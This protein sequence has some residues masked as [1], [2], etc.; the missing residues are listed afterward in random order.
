VLTALFQVVANNKMLLTLYTHDHVQLKGEHLEAV[1]STIPQIRNLTSLHINL[2]FTNESVLSSFRRNTSIVSLYTGSTADMVAVAD[3]NP[4]FADIAKRNDWI[5]FSNELLNS[6]P[7]K[8]L[9]LWANV[10]A[11]ITHRDDRGATAA[12]K[13]MR[14]RLIILWTPVSTISSM[15]SSAATAAAAASSRPNNHGSDSS[16]ASN[17]EEPEQKRPRLL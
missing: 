10:I 9:C 2:D 3:D 8:P 11:R 1:L 14:E 17:N 12:Y 7:Q 6:E 15:S 13:I 16:P 4:T 5:N